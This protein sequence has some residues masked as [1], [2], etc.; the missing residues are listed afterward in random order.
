M[1]VCPV[2]RQYCRAIENAS[3]L[4]RDLC[5]L[6]Q[7]YAR[8]RCPGTWIVGSGKA[9]FAGECRCYKATRYRGY[10]IREKRRECLTE[11]LTPD[12]PRRPLLTRAG[13]SIYMLCFG[14]IGA[15]KWLYDFEECD[16]PEIRAKLKSDGVNVPARC[17]CGNC[18]V[19]GP[20]DL[21]ASNIPPAS[22]Q[23]IEAG[24]FQAGFNV[25]WVTNHGIADKL[26][27]GRR[28]MLSLQEMDGDF[29]SQVLSRK[30][31]YLTLDA[32]NPAHF[33]RLV[34]ASFSSPVM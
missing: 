24:L 11:L 12:G 31:D 26:R 10:T 18:P 30:R 23:E 22:A 4:I 13:C 21:A 27:S 33:K 9:K 32:S 6:V 19:S 5:R 7:D 3:P 8:G 17:S 15:D 16:V 14:M 34:I 20:Y 1:S 2:D 25:Y 29:V 28:A